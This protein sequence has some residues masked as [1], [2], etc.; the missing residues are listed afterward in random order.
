MQKMA[1]RIVPL[2][3]KLVTFLI[4]GLIVKN[5]NKFT[6]HG[7]KN[8]SM[9]NCVGFSYQNLKILKKVSHTIES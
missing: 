5:Y 3:I 2:G 9:G 8:I 7:N 6:M 4:E 1:L